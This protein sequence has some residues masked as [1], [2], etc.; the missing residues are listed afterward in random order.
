MASVKNVCTIQ[1]KLFSFDAFPKLLAPQHDQEF[2]NAVRRHM[3]AFN[4]CFITWRRKYASLTPVVL[5]LFYISYPFIKQDHL[6]YPDAL[7]VAY[8]LKIRNQKIL[9]LD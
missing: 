9:Q 4:E 7:N 1:V 6:V 2:A 3:L 8:F 5:N